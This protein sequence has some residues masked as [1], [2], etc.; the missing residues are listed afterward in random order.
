MFIKQVNLDGLLGKRVR[1]NGHM[2][3]IVGYGIE[4]DENDYVVVYL[5]NELDAGQIIL[6]NLETV[7]LMAE[8]KDE[9]S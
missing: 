6:R 3:V 5:Q 9:I 4:H 2:F 8:V 7:F 1:L